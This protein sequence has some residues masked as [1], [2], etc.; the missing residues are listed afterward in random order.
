MNG[1]TLRLVKLNAAQPGVPSCDVTIE[2]IASVIDG[3]S[4]SVR[5]T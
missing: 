2:W 1:S 5:G 4:G 3:P